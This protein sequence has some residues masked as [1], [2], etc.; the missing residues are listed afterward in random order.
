MCSNITSKRS[1]FTNVQLSHY[2]PSESYTMSRV[3]TG[4]E[5]VMGELTQPPFAYCAKDK[6]KIEDINEKLHLIKVRY[7]DYVEVVEYGETYSNNSAN[8]IFL[9]Q[10]IEINPKIK[11]GSSV[12]KGDL[13]VYNTGFFD[14]DPMDNKADWKIGINGLVAFMEDSK[15]IEDSC[16]I[17]KSLA[18]QL[19][20]GIVYTRD[21]VL[22]RDTNIHKIVNRGDHVAVSDSLIVFDQ[23][24]S[25]PMIDDATDEEMIKLLEKLNRVTP[26]AKHAGT[27][28]DIK[29]YHTCP[30]EDMSSSLAETVKEVTKLQK[31]KV[32]FAKNTKQPIDMEAPGPLTETDKLGVVNL[33]KDTVILRFFIKHNDHM[34]AGSKIIFSSSL[35]SVNSGVEPHPIYTEDGEEVLAIMSSLSM[36]NRIVMSPKLHGVAARVLEHVEK[37]VLDMYF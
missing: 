8:G 37:Q 25:N 18:N 19:V 23:T 1:V 10:N 6:G 9:V 11:K 34:R 17:S 35:K 28:V 36:S 5:R 20:S 2:V 14:Y 32:N 24:G 15:A 7:K 16:I 12:K 33:D 30:I 21:V 3:R 13:I 4:F 27:I 22:S 31:Q 29:V 26:T